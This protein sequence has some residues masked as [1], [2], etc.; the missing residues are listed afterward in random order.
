MIQSMNTDNTQILSTLGRAKRPNQKT[1][2]YTKKKVKIV[3]FKA[4][5]HHAHKK[6]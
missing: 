6:V 2:R 5:P 4:H 3:F 1:S